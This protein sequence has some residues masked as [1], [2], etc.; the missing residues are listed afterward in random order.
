MLHGKKLYLLKWKLLFG[1]F[2]EGSGAHGEE[3]EDYRP[4]PYYTFTGKLRPCE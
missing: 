1:N 2:A 3:H 4:W